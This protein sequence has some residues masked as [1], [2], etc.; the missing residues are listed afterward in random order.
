V[1]LV[2]CCPLQTFD[3]CLCLCAV[4]SSWDSVLLAAGAT[5]V[6]NNPALVQALSSI[7][8]SNGRGA[9]GG[10]AHSHRHPPRL[11]VDVL[12]IDPLEYA[13]AL[14][15]SGGAGHS[16]ATGLSGR[17][18]TPT[19]PLPPGRAPHTGSGAKSPAP[20]MT[21]QELTAVQRCLAAQQLLQQQSAPHHAAS[22]PTAPVVVTT[23]WLVHCLAVGRLLDHTLVD[24]FTPPPQPQR[25]PH[26]YKADGVTGNGERYTKYDVVF[27]NTSGGSHS[28]ERGIRHS[29]TK[30]SKQHASQNL[31]I[32]RIEGFSRRDEFSPLFAR[33]SPLVPKA[34]IFPAPASRKGAGLDAQPMRNKELTGDPDVSAAMVEVERLCGKAVLLQRDDF[35]QVARYAAQDE[36]VFYASAEWE[37]SHPCLLPQAGYDDGYDQQ[38]GSSGSEAHLRKQCSQDY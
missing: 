6:Q 9:G 30:A 4:G 3:T 36:C 37:A 13:L 23:D 20:K 27:Y 35:K 31:E 11:V 16:A 25:K 26:T 38:Q 22:S 21:P 32:G 7:N 1:T 34:S 5:T 29:P 19:L 28:S 8:A 10:G 17:F 2:I 33:I 18:A 12:L 15:A 14:S 24:I